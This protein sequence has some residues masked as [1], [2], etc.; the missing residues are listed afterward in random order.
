MPPELMRA[1][2]RFTRLRRAEDCRDAAYEPMPR[3]AAV[4]RHLMIRHRR[5]VRRFRRDAACRAS[6]CR[7]FMNAPIFADAFEA[8]RAAQRRRR[9]AAILCRLFFTSDDCR[10][11]AAARDAAAHRAA[12]H[13]CRRLRA[14][15]PRLLIC[16]HYFSHAAPFTPPMRSEALSQTRQHETPMSFDMAAAALLFDADAYADTR[17]RRRYAIPRSICRRCRDFAR[18]PR[19]M[20]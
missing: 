6:E 1:P 19:L 8:Q 11:S 5:R 15:T 16:A 10:V 13:A 14:A 17:V 4:C 18:L 9:E 20:F 3:R 2:S 12:V 7:C